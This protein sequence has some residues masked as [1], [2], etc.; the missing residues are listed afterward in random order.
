[1]ATALQLTHGES[2]TLTFKPLAVVAPQ[3]LEAI[4]LAAKAILQAYPPI[5]NTLIDPPYAFVPND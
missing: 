1:V 3:A 4:L 5:Y 2:S